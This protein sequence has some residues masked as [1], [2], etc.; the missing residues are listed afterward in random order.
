MV[1]LLLEAERCP[2][3]GAS[4]KKENM[5]G[6]YERVHPKQPGFSG[7][8]TQTFAKSASFIKSR[9]NRNIGIVV[10]SVLL[11]IVIIAV[12]LTATNNMSGMGSNP[13]PGPAGS[14]AEFDYLSPI[15]TPCSWTDS[16]IMRM[17][18]STYLQGACCNGMVLT[19]Y[20]KQISELSNYASL[21]SV[22]ALDPFNIPAQVAKADLAGL[23]LAMTPDQQSTFN[24]APTLSS[25]NW[26]CCHCWAWDLHEGLGKILIVNYGYS[27]QQVAHVIDLE[28]CC[29]TAPGAMRM[30]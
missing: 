17:S 30:S 22:V 24:Q 19:D 2:F 27:A 11:S 1:A 8:P 21:S 16:M 20:Q 3:C 5:K 6:H 7:R 23:S 25:E 26:C 29:G 10:G 28:G 18:D 14:Q 9:R 13:G 15:A 12:T 4:V